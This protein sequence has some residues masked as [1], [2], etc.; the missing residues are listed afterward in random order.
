VITFGF[1]VSCL[2]AHGV[3]PDWLSSVREASFVREQG[4]L[5]VLFGVSV[6][7][8]FHLGM[9]GRSGAMIAKVAPVLALLGWVGLVVA[10]AAD[11]Q[12]IGPAGWRCAARM[13]G[14]ALAPLV[15]FI[16]GLRRVPLLYPQRMTAFAVWA[17]CSVAMF[18]TQW[19]CT[20]NAPLHVLVWHCGPVTLAGLIGLGASAWLPR[21]AGSGLRSSRRRE[22]V[23]DEK[24]RPRRIS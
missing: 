23:G 10:R 7:G 15:G 1:V 17:A 3:R 13:A 20:R 6:W 16:V 11:A 21:S 18:G 5:L 4:A 8:V 2:A 12:T 9:P 19:L 24:W 14:L 22:A